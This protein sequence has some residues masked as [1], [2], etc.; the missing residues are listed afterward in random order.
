MSIENQNQINQIRELNDYEIIPP[1]IKC[2]NGY[3]INDDTDLCACYPGWESSCDYNEELNILYECDLDLGANRTDLHSISNKDTLTTGVVS[4]KNTSTSYINIYFYI[5]FSIFIITL[6]LLV[7]LC[8]WKRY[9][10]IKYFSMQIK[11]AKE[12]EKNNNINYDT[13]NMKNNID[14]NND[15][16]EKGMGEGCLRY[17]DIT[18]GTT[19]SKHEDNEYVNNIRNDISQDDKKEIEL[20]NISNNYDKNQETK[21]NIYQK[22]VSFSLPVKNLGIKSNV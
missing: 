3:F 7:I 6:L 5:C 13:R 16:L 15:Y 10:Q 21:G 4:E 9:K 22:K 12:N 19:I 17:S 20:A 18:R 8:L 11:K 14:N 1:K 2:V